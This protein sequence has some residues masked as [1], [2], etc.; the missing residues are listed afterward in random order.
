[1]NRAALR[2]LLKEELRRAGSLVMEAA[3]ATRVPAG[4]ALAVDRQLFAE[5]IT[6]KIE[7]QPKI[8]TGPR[9]SDSRFPMTR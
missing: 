6:A 8:R 3:A 9:R 5:Y 2:I 7:A 1:M 4:A